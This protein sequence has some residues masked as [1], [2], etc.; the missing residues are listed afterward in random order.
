MPFYYTSILVNVKPWAGD[1]L[2]KR[3]FQI[4]FLFEIMLMNFL[5]CFYM[6]TSEIRCESP[7]PLCGVAPLSKYI[8]N[9]EAGGSAKFWSMLLICR[10]K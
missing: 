5:H 4:C 10:M 3:G 1:E 8:P 6:K 7:Q 9:S 2:E